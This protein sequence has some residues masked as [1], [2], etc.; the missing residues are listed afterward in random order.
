M[1]NLWISPLLRSK[2]KQIVG[3]SREGELNTRHSIPMLFQWDIT[4]T[5]NFYDSF[6]LNCT[7]LFFS[8]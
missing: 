7:A 6:K 5:G 1:Q 3:V 2:R 8:E 4:D